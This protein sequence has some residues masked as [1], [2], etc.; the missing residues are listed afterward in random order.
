MIDF[1]ERTAVMTEFENSTA[2]LGE[3]TIPAF[4]GM[5][6]I[7]CDQRAANRA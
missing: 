4:A 5:S 3:C 2:R 6:G 7:Y 1:L